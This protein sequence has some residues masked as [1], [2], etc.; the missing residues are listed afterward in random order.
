MDDAAGR[1]GGSFE[2]GDVVALKSG[3]PH[4]TV[5]FV[6]GD[7]VSCVW[8]GRGGTRRKQYHAYLLRLV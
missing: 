8:V 1:S 6:K 7:L 5:E 3:S 4:M 2:A